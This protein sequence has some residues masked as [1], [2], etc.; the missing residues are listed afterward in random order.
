VT[1]YARE[2]L[3]LQIAVGL[4]AAVPV[5]AGVWGVIDGLS[6]PGA[7]I[8]GHYRYLSG[9]LLGIGLSYWAMIPVIER[10]KWPF[11]MLSAIVVLGGMARGGAALAAGSGA[12]VE[13]ALIMEL[14]VTPGLFLWRERIGSLAPARPAVRPAANLNEQESRDVDETEATG[15]GGPW[16]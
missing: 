7:F 2:R 9:L 15:Y 8:D 10:A 4:A 13:L 3:A 12:A 1:P 11:R 16:S 5:L 6:A 14:I